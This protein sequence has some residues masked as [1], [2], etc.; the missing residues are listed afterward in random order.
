MNPGDEPAFPERLR[1]SVRGFVSEGGLTKREW[2]AAQAM[3]G[4]LA[5]GTSDERLVA[6]W[7]VDYADA[8]LAELERRKPK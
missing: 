1:G 2:F 5:E 6:K 7:A 3:Q 4:L 8:V